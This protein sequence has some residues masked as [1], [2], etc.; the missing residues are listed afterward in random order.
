MPIH[1]TRRRFLHTSLAASASLTMGSRLTADDKP[2]SPNERINIGIIGVNGRGAGN[3]AG[4]AGENIVALCDVDEDRAKDARKNYPK[5]TFTQDFR[6]LLDQKDIDAVVISTPDHMHAI[7]AVRA[8]QAGK[9][10]YCE[11]PLAHSV[12]EVRVMMALAAKQKVATQMG[13]QIHAED[14]YRR[15]VEV[16][17]SGVLGPIRRVHVWCEKKP[18]PGRMARQEAKIPAG[19]N[20]DLWLGPAPH[21]PYHPAHVHFNW[22]WWWDFGGGVLGDMACHY[23]DLP[24]WALGLRTPTRVSAVGKVTYE[25]DNQMPDLMQVEYF[26]AARGEQPPVQLTWYHG[27]RGPDLSGKVKY[28]KYGSGVLFEGDRGKLLA[29]YSKYRLLPEEQF[30]DFTPPKQ[31]IAKS[32]GH[33]REWLNAIRTGSPTTCNFAYSG[34]LAEAVLLGNVAYR[35]RQTIECDGQA[36]RV[37][38]VPE[39]A[40][41]LQREYRKGWTLGG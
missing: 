17:Q 36:G 35:C 41:Y 16:V 40:A 18:D 2:A 9:H 19:L 15:V 14:N 30:K 5:A 39:A 32:V 3:L 25:G 23:M 7:P 13:T 28:D 12:Q 22:R 26:Y 33:H 37:T 6:R 21:R 10:V 31:S 29:D 1:L 27:V 34:A 20:Y 4:V 38:N 11:K 24:H 8:M